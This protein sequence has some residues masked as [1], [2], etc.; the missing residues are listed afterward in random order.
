MYV[1]ILQCSDNSLYVGVTNNLEM[2]FEQHV[3][4][5]NVNC[6]TYLRRPLKIVY[7][8][9]FNSPQLAIA[10]EKKLKKWTRA[11][12]LALINNDWENLKKLSACN[13]ETN[14][15]NAIAYTSTPLSETD[16]VFVIE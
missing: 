6:Y 15:K 5:I 12:K 14:H 8:E 7:H 2:R 13:N 1:Y 9:L 10:F 4:G 3:Q 11:K 16:S